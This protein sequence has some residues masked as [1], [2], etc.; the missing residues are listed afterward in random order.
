MLVLVAALLWIAPVGATA[1]QGAP[2]P[3]IEQSTAATL[4]GIDA[5]GR[6]LVAL[7]QRLKLRGT[8]SIPLVVNA[9]TPD[10]SVSTRHPFFVAN[11][12]GKGYYTINATVRYVTP[13]AYWYVKDG[14]SV[15]QRF[16][17][18]SANRFETHVYPTNRRVFGP[19]TPPGSLGIDN[20][21]RI[22][23]LIA[24]ISGVGGYFSSSDTYPR[25]VNPYSNQRDMIYMSV[26]PEAGSGGRYNYFEA[27]LAH[28]FQHMIEWG[29]KR[30]RDVWLDE[31]SS[32]VASFVNGYDAGGSDF[33]FVLEPD[34][35]LNTWTDIEDSS[36]H[37]GASYLF[38]RYLMERYGGEGF[39]SALMKQDGLGAKAID[40]VVKRAGGNAGF[41]GAFK[42]WTVANVLK[43]PAIAGG[44]Y[45]Y[46]EGGRVT[47]DI[48]I[49]QYPATRADSV[50]QYAA[51]YISLNGALPRGGTIAFKGNP[52]VRV[53][54]ADPH[55]GQNFW[56]SN[57]RDSGDATLTREFDLTRVRAA[58]LRFWAW[59]N[60]EPNYDYAYVEAST[61]GGKSWATLKGKYTTTENPNGANFGNA[62]TGISLQNPK[63]K[64]QNPQWVEEAISL[65][66]YVGRK[67]M[68]RFEYVTDEGYN[69]PGFALD[70]IRVPEIGYAD[71]AETQA[72]GWRAEGF[73]RIG[74]RLPQRWFVA[75]V[76]RGGNGRPNSV[77]E[78]VVNA[79]GAGMIDLS[80]L[81]AGRTSRNDILVIVPLAPKTTELANWTVTVRGR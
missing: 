2:A 5:P 17:E 1:G 24:P 32:E 30:Q 40:A 3:P 15:N 66:A 68:V 48:T 44:R 54:G 67:V 57:R 7:T 41:E 36:P 22:T 74:S 4:V 13:H 47:P 37:Y 73:V 63:S 39:M 52:L 69:K 31:G 81:A 23:V 56:Y 55:S 80:P 71:N 77:R 8:G 70:D 43:D 45:N 79:N 75:L 42:D 9:T 26:V 21:P 35:Q 50:H 51:D 27:T 14:F 6:D 10:Y 60:I 18:A 46:T 72:G 34:T 28:E 38:L 78:M 62:W 12:T 33:S 20:D 53:I 61:D 11:I 25:V 16:L 29:Q 59:Y 58:T 76:E 49:K 64:V 65:N 19:E